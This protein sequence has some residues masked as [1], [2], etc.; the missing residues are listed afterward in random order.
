MDNEQSK[1]DP[2][3][4]LFLFKE[5]ENQIF[6]NDSDWAILYTN[7]IIE[8][9]KN[10]HVPTTKT[11][12]SLELIWRENRDVIGDI[13]SAERMILFSQT[14]REALKKYLLLDN[15]WIMGFKFYKTVPHI[16]KSKYL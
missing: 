9:L 3:V 10:N 2:R 1:P 4:V 15:G 8:P 5:I 14:K 16:L 13:R 11:K 6:E 7:D 12:K